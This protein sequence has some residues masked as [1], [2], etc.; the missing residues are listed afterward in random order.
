MLIFDQDVE[1]K[2]VRFRHEFF[3]A[4]HHAFLTHAVLS[5]LFSFTHLNDEINE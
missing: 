3:P 2:G 5:F 4:R 1:K